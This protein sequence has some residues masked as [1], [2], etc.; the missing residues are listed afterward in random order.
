MSKQPI[1]PREAALQKMREENR[2]AAD[3]AM[4]ADKPATM[5]ALK[6]AT[7]EAS[8]KRGKL[9]KRKPKK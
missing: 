7:A 1:G 8:K 2:A 6:N 9:L 4:K 5:A 3:A